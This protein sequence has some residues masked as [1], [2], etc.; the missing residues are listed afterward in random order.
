MKGRADAR[1]TGAEGRATSSTVTCYGCLYEGLDP[2][3]AVSDQ[4]DTVP[5]ATEPQSLCSRCTVQRRCA[6]PLG[7]LIVLT[8]SSSTSLKRDPLAPHRVLPSPQVPVECYSSIGTVRGTVP[9]LSRR[10]PSPAPPQPTYYL[11]R[12]S[13]L[14]CTAPLS[15]TKTVHQ[16][17]CIAVAA[18]RKLV[19]VAR[20][21]AG[22]AA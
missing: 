12:P 9:I 10:H 19:Y 14:H 4:N 18:S 11:P 7:C 3:L 21:N 15:F 22:P 8:R 16:S 1:K 6:L 13:V 17:H 5:T 2:A 20:P